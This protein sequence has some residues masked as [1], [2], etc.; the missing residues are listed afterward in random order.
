MFKRVWTYPIHHAFGA[1]ETDGDDCFVAARHTQLVSVS[2]QTGQ[3]RWS[4]RIESPHGWLAFNDRSAFYLNQHAYLIAVDRK[5]GEHRWSRNLSGTNGWLHALG[6]AVVVG[7]WRGYTDILAID[8]DDGK[9]CWTRSARNGAL[10]ST[11]IHAESN[12]L[13]VADLEA[14]RIRFIRLTDGVEIADS[15]V[16]W[17]VPYTEHP[18]GTTR[19]TEPLVIKSSEHQ[20]LAITGTNPDIE[21]VAVE[22]NI[23]S[24][25]VSSSGSV[26]PFVTS[27][28]ELLAWHLV[29]RRM[30]NFGLLQHNRRDILPFCQVSADSFVAGTS[31]GELHHFTQSGRETARS[32]VGK[33]IATG[34]SL[35]GTTAVCGTDSGELIGLETN[36]DA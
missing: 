8:A 7:G 28:R 19:S 16:E 21:V 9:T 27:R 11:R 23:W 31:F 18:T 10:H 15:A 1:F 5:T 25:N 26:V 22:A 29:E 3:F 35:A 4:T 6:G 14:K 20:F 13:V 34:I 30:L 2:S 32:K 33:R 24:E 12:T 17:D 36:V